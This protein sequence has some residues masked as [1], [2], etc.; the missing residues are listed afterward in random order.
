GSE[1]GRAA[2]A[3][4]RRAD[5]N[6]PGSIRKAHRGRNREVG[7]G[8]E[9]L[10]R[11]A[12]L[13]RESSRRSSISSRSANSSPA[14]AISGLSV[15]HHGALQPGN[16]QIHHGRDDRENGDRSH[17]DVHFEDLTAVL[18]EIAETEI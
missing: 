14:G 2:G 17:D 7:E 11:Q 15:P 18:D 5:A 3:A 6:A 8:R 12:G 9:V 16:R 4:R 10:G 13:I 1:G